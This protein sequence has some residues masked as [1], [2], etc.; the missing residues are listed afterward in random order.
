MFV[1]RPETALEFHRRRS[2]RFRLTCLLKHKSHNARPMFTRAKIIVSFLSKI[3][4]FTE[5]FSSVTEN[6]P[7]FFHFP[8]DN[9][10]TN[11]YTG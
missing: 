3:P 11:T 2:F 8:L 7:F 5:S 9:D 6:Q 4:I 1:F 10:Q